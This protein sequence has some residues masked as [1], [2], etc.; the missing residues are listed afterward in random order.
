[1][2]NTGSNGAP[3]MAA[4]RDSSFFARQ[5]HDSG[6]SKYHAIV[7]RDAARGRGP[8]CGYPLH[9]EEAELDSRQVEVELRCNRPGCRQAFAAAD[10]TRASGKA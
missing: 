2:T 10:Q 7:D 9:D 6:S 5:A 8:A 3:L 1:M 4:V